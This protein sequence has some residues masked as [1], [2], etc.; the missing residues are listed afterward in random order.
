MKTLTTKPRKESPEEDIVSNWE[1]TS[2]TEFTCYVW[3]LT[4]IRGFS[5]Y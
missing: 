1:I 2:R 5:S 4:E 3:K